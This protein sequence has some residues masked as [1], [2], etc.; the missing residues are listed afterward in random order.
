MKKTGFYIIRDR[1]FEDMADPYLKGNKA[2]NRPHYY[3]F[4]DNCFWKEQRKDRLP[5]RCNNLWLYICGMPF[6]LFC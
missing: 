1:F 5:Y 4:S 2:G 6:L 3:C